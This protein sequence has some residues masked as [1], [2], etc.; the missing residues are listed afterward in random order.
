MTDPY[1]RY[2]QGGASLSVRREWCKGCDLCVAACPVDILSL[3]KA[4]L[5]DVIDI[6]KCIFC[7]LCAER[8]PDFCFSITRPEA[9]VPYLPTNS[10]H[11]THPG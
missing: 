9:V 4:N 7:G 6:S 2:N 10:I 5:I 3:D 11:E 8:C 1:K